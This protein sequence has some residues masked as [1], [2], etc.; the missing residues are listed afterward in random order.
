L[1]DVPVLGRT[2]WLDGELTGERLREL[3]EE[4][5]DV[6]ALAGAAIHPQEVARV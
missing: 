6:G 2:P 1:A 3:V 4:H 5:V